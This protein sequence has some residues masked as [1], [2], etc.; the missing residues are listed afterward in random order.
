MGKI[1][2]WAITKLILIYQKYISPIK[3]PSCRFYP[4]CSTYAIQALEKYGAMKGLW[5]IV[6]RILRCHPFNPGG[7]DPV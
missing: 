5:M 4:S 7:Y 1:M 3:N 2:V 6:R